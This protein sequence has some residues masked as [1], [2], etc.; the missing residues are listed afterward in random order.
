[1]KVLL[2]H[3]SL[4]PYVARDLEILC[5]SHEVRTIQF[6]GLKGMTKFFIPDFWKLWKGVLWCDLTFCWFGKLHA[7]FSVLFCKM[8]RRKSIVIA[9]GEDAS[10]VKPFG[11]IGHPLKKWFTYFVF[12]YT[13]K[14]I[15]VSHFN[16]GEVLHSAKA[17]A[18]KTTIVY[19]GFDF[20]FFHKITEEK[21]SNSVATVAHIR[22]DTYTRKGL[23]LF[24]TSAKLL[25]GFDFYLI[26]PV[27]E[28]GTYKKL[29]E[30]AP[31]NVYFTGGLYGQDLVR[32]L[33]RMSVYVQVSEWESFGCSLAEAMLC[34]CVPVVYRRTALPEVVG[35]AGYYIESL[36]AEEL[37]EAIQMAL[38]DKEMGSKARAR[39]IR[40]FPLEKRRQKILNVLESLY[41]YTNKIPSGRDFIGAR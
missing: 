39:I 1:M 22:W 27:V 25:P 21:R 7:F 13:D 3:Q 11:I 26:G 30:I 41:S 16:L 28:D 4:E 19:H 38:N 20:N 36:T 37:S 17:P 8:L 33:S 18:K 14:I 40:N 2:V 32:A 34:E 23:K 35:K 9:G 5:S 10:A 15:A 12:R 6:T 29:R 31:P 24:V